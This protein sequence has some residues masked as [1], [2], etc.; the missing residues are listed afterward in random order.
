MKNNGKIPPH[1]LYILE[2]E[3]I[4]ISE[5][6]SSNMALPESFDRMIVKIPYCNKTLDIQVIFDSIN[7]SNPPDFIL[8]KEETLLYNYQELIKEWNFKDS[9]T[10]Q[11]C[12]L[13]IKNLFLLSQEKRLRAEIERNAYKDDAADVIMRGG[14]ISDY[15][16]FKDEADDFGNAIPNLWKTIEKVFNKLKSKMSKYKF[17][18]VN[19]LF[20]NCK[21]NNSLSGANNANFSAS[22]SKSSFSGSGMKPRQNAYSN[23]NYFSYLT[24]NNDLNKNFSD[25]LNNKAPQNYIYGNKDHDEIN[26]N[27][28]P[29]VT[30]NTKQSKMPNHS[31]SNN[32]SNININNTYNN[33]NNPPSSNLNLQHQS[34]FN[35]QNSNYNN[36]SNKN[37]NF[38]L[39]EILPEISFSYNQKD[40]SALFLEYT[41]YK[42]CICFAYPLDLE[43]RSRNV[44]RFPYILVTIYLNYDMKFKLDLL[45]P[46][47][48]NVSNFK[49]NN[50]I[51]AKFSSSSSN[52][53][54]DL[55]NFDY[56]LDNYEISVLDYFRDMACRET[57][58]NKILN[59]NLGFTLE[60][61]S[62][63]FRKFSQYIHCN[64]RSNFKNNNNLNLSKKGDRSS[65][66]SSS[67]FLASPN[68]KAAYQSFFNFIICYTFGKEDAK[69]LQ[70]NIIDSDQLSNI[71]TKKFPYSNSNSDLE[72]LINNVFE[73]LISN[74]NIKLNQ[75]QS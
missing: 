52:E 19:N 10:L 66:Q 20:G 49:T 32:N 62:A 43:L 55:K 53:F 9:S 71:C 25:N 67:N 45:T 58:V 39:L 6:K 33:I 11:F 28:I 3:E 56:V 4:Q 36:N 13:K 75:S 7:N 1:F 27:E 40:S 48:I 29:S 64:E 54:F 37:N 30:N 72:N 65:S 38:P 60:I 26:I 31:N 69:V 8:I 12:L 34:S 61:D 21:A 16:N 17:V 44:P 41:E 14:E 50:N 63:G 68:Q 2:S 51:S 59:L 74:V 35:T 47:F 46:S 15:N 73:F 57:I 18:D 23:N 42:H 70:V 24:P 5:M 22:G